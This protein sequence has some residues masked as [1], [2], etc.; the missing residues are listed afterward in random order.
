[1]SCELIQ[2]ICEEDEDIDG[3]DYIFEKT[4]KYL[5]RDPVSYMMTV[6]LKMMTPW[7]PKLISQK[8]KLGSPIGIFFLEEDGRYFRD[9]KRGR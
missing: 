3:D 7:H 2:K 4:A 5:K 9:L 6:G 1:M 8:H